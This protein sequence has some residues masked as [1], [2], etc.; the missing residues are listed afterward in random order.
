MT[1][2]A[3]ARRRYAAIVFQEAK[4]CTE[5]VAPSSDL[6]TDHRRSDNHSESHQPQTLRSRC[7]ADSRERLSAGQAPPSKFGANCGNE[8]VGAERRPRWSRARARTRKCTEPV[9]PSSGFPTDRRRSGCRSESHRPRAL[10]TRCIFDSR[11]ARQCRQGVLERTCHKLRSFLFAQDQTAVDPTCSR[12]RGD[13]RAARRPEEPSAPRRLRGAEVS[14]SQ[15]PEREKKFAEPGTLSSTFPTNLPLPR[16]APRGASSYRRPVLGA[17]GNL[18]DG[19]CPIKG[20]PAETSRYLQTRAL[21]LV[22]RRSALSG[23]GSHH[24]RRGDRCRSTI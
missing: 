22:D 10:R 24:H 14:A 21:E 8:F 1:I 3:A 17:G 7:I 12:W 6:P 18:G 13:E 23:D 11:W 19:T 20:C 9:A 16:S 2:P 15:A 5:P 4:K